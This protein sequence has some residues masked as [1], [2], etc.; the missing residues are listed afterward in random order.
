MPQMKIGTV[1]ANLETSTRAREFVAYARLLAASNGSRLQAREMAQRQSVS[2]R[3]VEVLKS[4]V[5]AGGLGSGDWGEQLGDLGNMISA[6]LD[7]LK[8]YGAFD[9]MLPA[10]K[11]VPLRTRL[12]LVV[13]GA[14]GAVVASGHV[15]P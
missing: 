12:G 1:A 7:S 2:P 8:N 14:T 4:A 3:V 5:S 13:A 6:F 9:A 10:M 11:R 15:T